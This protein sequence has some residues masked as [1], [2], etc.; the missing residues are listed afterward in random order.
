VNCLV[1]ACLQNVG[2]NASFCDSHL[3][4][5]LDF[6]GIQDP[7]A[8]AAKAAEWQSLAGREGLNGRSPSRSEAITATE[9]IASNEEAQFVQ[10]NPGQFLAIAPVPV[11]RHQDIRSGNSRVRKEWSQALIKAASTVRD[12]RF[13]TASKNVLAVL[14]LGVLFFGA[15]T[16]ASGGRPVNAANPVAAAPQHVWTAQVVSSKAVPSPKF[17]LVTQGQGKLGFVSAGVAYGVGMPIQ[18]FKAHFGK[19]D[20]EETDLCEYLSDGLAVFT[21]AGNIERFRFFDVP[22]EGY[23][24]AKLDVDRGFDLH[25]SPNALAAIYQAPL[26]L[27]GSDAVFQLPGGTISYNYKFGLIESVTLESEV[28][29]PQG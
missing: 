21:K 22:V 18:D 1:P 10:P 25:Y 13:F 3:A 5:Y 19:P 12:A 4:S 24:A 26:Q 23:S 28:L 15:Y 29:D 20:S 6:L 27:T 8:R 16:L 11:A 14:G 9:D 7:G 17:H 2:V